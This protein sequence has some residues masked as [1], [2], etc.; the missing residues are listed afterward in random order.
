M[1]SGIKLFGEAG[2]NA[3][4]KALK[5]LHDRKVL[6]PRKASQLSSN[7]KKAALQHLMFLKKK[8]SRVI[9]G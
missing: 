6:E 7:E 3:V 2:V 9:K 8:C 1:K 5:R 4:L